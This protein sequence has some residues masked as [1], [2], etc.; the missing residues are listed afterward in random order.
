MDVPLAPKHPK[1]VDVTHQGQIVVV[2]AFGFIQHSPTVLYEDS[3]PVICMAENPVNRKASR[4]IDTRKH[5][6]GEAVAA[7]LIKLEPCTTKKMVADTL[8]KNLP[9]PT[10]ERHRE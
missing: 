1:K 7:K 5:W 2:D 10:F 3:R 4:H 9:A 6:I 8:T